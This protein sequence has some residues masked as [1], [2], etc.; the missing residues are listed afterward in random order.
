[1]GIHFSGFTSYLLKA[2]LNRFAMVGFCPWIR[3][4]VLNIRAPIQMVNKVNRITPTNP[5]IGCQMGMVTGVASLITIIVGVNGGIRERV[6]AR[7]PEGSWITGTMIKRGR[8]TGI[9]AGNCRDCASLLSLHVAPSAAIPE[10]IIMMYRTVN[11]KNQG[12]RSYGIRDS[13]PA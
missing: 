8:I 6:V 1:V 4:A 12:R 9:I 7:L 2:Y 5:A 10:P 13:T 3:M 11:T